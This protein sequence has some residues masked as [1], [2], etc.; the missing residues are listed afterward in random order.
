MIYIVNNSTSFFS[1]SH[2]IYIYIYIPHGRSPSE[3]IAQRSAAPPVGGG[4]HPGGVSAGGRRRRKQQAEV[5]EE[6]K[7]R[8][9]THRVSTQNQTRSIS[10]LK[11]K[12]EDRYCACVYIDDLTMQLPV[13]G[14]GGLHVI[15]VV[16]ILHVPTRSPRRHIFSTIR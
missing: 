12:S 8:K 11:L 4:G 13:D 7:H 10:S 16:S 6:K 3:A 1:S 9:A 15:L 5:E 2:N 14:G